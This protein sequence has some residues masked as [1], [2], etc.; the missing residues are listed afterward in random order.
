MAKYESYGLFQTLM[1]LSMWMQ[2]TPGGVSL[3]GI[4]DRFE[5]SRRTAE[6]MRDA[7]AGIF[8]S[9]FVEIP[10]GSRKTFKINSTVMEKLTLASFTEE[11]LGALNTAS[12]CLRASSLSPKADLIDS[13]GE[14]LKGVLN[15][16]TAKSVNLEDIMKSEGMAMRPAPRIRMDQNTVALIREAIM[17]FHTVRITYRNLKGEEREHT[18]VPLGFIFGERNHYLA[19]RYADGSADGVRNFILGRIKGAEITREVFE[20]DPSFSLQRYA[21][22]S[23]GAFQEEPFDCEWLFSPEA[24]EEASGMTFHPTQTCR[25]N[26]DGSLTVSFR[27]GGRLEMAWHLYT[28]GDGVKVIKPDDFWESLPEEGWRFP[29][30]SRAS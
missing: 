30:R 19:A 3:T 24:A 29:K 11:E 28:W 2:A 5:V 10:D 7:V 6:R 13:L 26:P 17:S 22:R 8:T 23:F 14:K 20:E 18:L 9:D 25:R 27:A 12:G 21:E 1:R 15:F 4:M 16:N